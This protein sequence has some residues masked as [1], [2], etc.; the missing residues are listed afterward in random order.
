MQGKV[1]HSER[2]IYAKAKILIVD[3][4]E[5]NL[6]LLQ[7]ILSKAG[8][9]HIVVT[10]DSR[11]VSQICDMLQ[12]DLILLDLTMPYLDGFQVMQQLTPTFTGGTYLPILVLTTDIAPEAKRQALALGAKDFLTK[13]LD[14]V[15]VLLR[16]NNLLET[17]FLY[18]ELQGRNEAL[19]EQMLERTRE[20]EQAQFEILERLTVAA[21]YRDDETGQHTR[22]VGY[23]STLLARASGLPQHEV[24]LIERVAPLH[25]LGKIGIPDDILLKP[26][27][28]TPY[29]FEV[30]KTHTIIGARILS[31]GHSDMV[32]M[33]QT[34]ALTHH[35]CWDGTG[36]P[37]R[38]QGES[39]PRVGRIVAL[40]DT[41]DALTHKRPYKD[42]WPLDKA[43][44]EIRGQRG[45]QFDPQL[46]DIFL[47]IDVQTLTPPEDTPAG[48]SGPGF[49]SLPD[50]L[51]SCVAT[52]WAVR[53][54]ETLIL[55]GEVD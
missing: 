29:E 46:V 52:T 27:K 6:R 42:A 4:Q 16:I 11:E 44:E 39:I 28:L 31:G 3:D 32:K 51:H 22:R 7:A 26:A 10:A 5:A 43:V 8:Y 37:H 47:G 36:Y 38:L 55:K 34:I 48:L 12:P 30:M 20:L 23:L 33:A 35:E 9:T 40:A 14:D 53:D 1:A 17:R 18:L 24:E 45:K 41:F 21:E 49:T 54:R 15:E 25:D 19:E 2:S 50:F 13:P